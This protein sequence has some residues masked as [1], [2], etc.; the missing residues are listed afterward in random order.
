MT[1]R[2]VRIQGWVFPLFS[3]DSDDRLSLNFHRFVILYLSCDTRSVC[4]GKYCLTKG[5]NGFKGIVLNFHRLI[6][7]SIRW[8]RFKWMDSKINLWKFHCQHVVAFCCK[9]GAVMSIPGRH[10]LLRNCYTQSEKHIWQ[11]C[12]SD[13]HFWGTSTEVKWFLKCII[14]L[15]TVDT[16]GY[17]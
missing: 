11:H 10:S 8:K 4:L 6:L 15:K 3:P 13:S 16:I 14:L 7:L 5:S 12:F 17:C 9:Y 2:N 1:R